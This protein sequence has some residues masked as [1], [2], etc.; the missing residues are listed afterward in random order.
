[1]SDA[2]TDSVEV[3]IAESADGIR[4][5]SLRITTDDGKI[6][7]VEPGA[8]TS[9]FEVDDGGVGD[10]RVV[11]RAVDFNGEARHI[12]EPTRL[13][14]VSFDTPIPLETIDLGIDSMVDHLDDPVDESAV[15]FRATE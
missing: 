5:F 11:A 1:M 8:L 13:V 9:H 10:Q 2:R 4:R 12:T 14:A 3:L 6:T 15:R 7:A